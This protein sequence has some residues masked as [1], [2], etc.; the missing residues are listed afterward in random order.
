[1]RDADRRAVEDH[2]IP[3]ILLMER[4][5]LASAEAILG[6]LPGTGAALVV[7]GAGNNGGDGMVVARHL[8]EA[9]WEVEV[10]APDG[11]GAGDAR[12]RRHDRDRRE[13]RHRGRPLDTDAAA[14]VRAVVVDALLGT[15]ARGAPRGRGGRARWSG[16]PAARRAG[17]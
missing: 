11:P 8:A 3:S 9:G 16:S 6:A 12:R 13:P 1:M 14:P 15:G 17:A 2:A 5:G 7:V 4:A 10:A